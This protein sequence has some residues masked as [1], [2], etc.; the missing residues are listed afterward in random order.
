MSVTVLIFTNRFFPIYTTIATTAILSSVWTFYT[1]P[2]INEEKRSTVFNS[3]KCHTYT[4]TLT[5]KRKSESSPLPREKNK[6]FFAQFSYVAL[7]SVR[8]FTAH[9]FNLISGEMMM[10]RE[11]FYNEFVSVCVVGTE[12]NCM[13]V[14]ICVSVLLI[15]TL[16]HA[17]YFVFYSPP[18]HS[19]IW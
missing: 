2:K 14:C 11:S 19:T 17:S 15:F 10:M 16:S 3:N 1:S 4:H 12:T 5:Q 6:E 18:F 7:V 8:F 13:C 9:S